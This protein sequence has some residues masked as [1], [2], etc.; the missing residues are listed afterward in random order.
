[1]PER[2]Q[3]DATRHRGRVWNAV[4]LDDRRLGNGWLQHTAGRPYSSANS[5]SSLHAVVTQAHT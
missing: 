4:S 5:R 1:M 3:P 2:N